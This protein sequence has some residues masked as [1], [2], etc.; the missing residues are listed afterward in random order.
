MK[1][2][3]I[4]DDET[5]TCQLLKHYLMSQQFDVATSCTLAAGIQKIADYHP[6]ILFL[7]NDLPDGLGWERA[8][9]LASCNPW[10]RIKLISGTELKLSPEQRQK[11]EVIEKPLS[12]YKINAALA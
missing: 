3:L 10:L 6:D 8:W 12:V 2:I 7:D 4:I 11:F 9:D 1:K 5:N